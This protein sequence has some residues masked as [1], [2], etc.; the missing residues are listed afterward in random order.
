MS[1]HAQQMNLYKISPKHMAYL[2]L[3]HKTSAIYNR[4]IL[5]FALKD[6]M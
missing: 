4:N 3:W 6:R 5:S 1:E 2:T